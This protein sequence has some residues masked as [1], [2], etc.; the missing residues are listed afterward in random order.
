MTAMYIR[1]I[2]DKNKSSHPSATVTLPVSG[3]GSLVR[4][5]SKNDGIR[6]FVIIYAWQ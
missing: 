3:S 1:V 5:E 6:F 2:D 4:T